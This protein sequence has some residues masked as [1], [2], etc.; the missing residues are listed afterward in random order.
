MYQ[1]PIRLTLNNIID[2]VILLIRIVRI[3]VCLDLVQMSNISP[4]SNQFPPKRKSSES[5]KPS[6]DARYWGRKAATR[7]AYVF[8][9]GN[10]SK[11]P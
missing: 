9:T 3:N 7:V 5:D 4:F 6:K 8:C 2:E 10:P 11:M 1:V